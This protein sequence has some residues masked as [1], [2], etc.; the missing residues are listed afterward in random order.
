MEYTIKNI[1]DMIRD[2][3]EGSVENVTNTL[4]MNNDNVSFKITDRDENGN[5]KRFKITVEE[6]KEQRMKTKNI[7]EII[8]DRIDQDMNIEGLIMTPNMYD[9]FKYDGKMMF[10]LLEKNPNGS[11]FKRFTITI[12]DNLSKTLLSKPMTI[13]DLPCDGSY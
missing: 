4:Q 7:V 1:A 11:V 10:C 8:K 5:S 9:P 2:R 13:N 3:I 12:D 6:I